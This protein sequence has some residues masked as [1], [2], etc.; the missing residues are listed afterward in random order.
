MITRLRVKNYKSLKDLDLRLR[1]LTVF[2]GPNNAG[3]SNILDSLIFLSDLVKHSDNAT[4]N[5]GGLP[6]IVWDGDLS[7]TI[8]ILLEGKIEDVQH[9]HIS[10]RYDIE[11]KAEAQHLTFS[12]EEFSVSLDGEER[13]LLDFSPSGNGANL[14]DIQR[15]QYVPHAKPPREPY[16]RDAIGSA[17]YGPLHEFAKQVSEWARY[18]FYAPEMRNSPDAR[19]ALRLDPTGGN[20]SAVLHTLQ[21]EHRERLD[22]IK[23]LLKVVV[24]DIKKLVSPLTPQGKVT[25]RAEEEGLSMPVFLRMLSNGTLHTLA[26]FAALYTPDPPPL[27]CFEEPENYVHPAVL[28]VLAAAFR[29]ASRRSQILI[30][31]H[32]PHLLNYFE[33]QD[34][35]IVEKKRG[36]TTARHVANGKV[37]KE[38]LDVMGLGEFWYSGALGGVPR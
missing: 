29:G 14:Y 27:M 34:V 28:D 10:F 11:G 23:D 17:S 13:K 20:L 33:V 4:D 15:R 2:V 8:S 35:V 12:R 16:L 36:S 22:R 31:T 30:A 37:L 9:R 18:E 3:K 21:S 25:L 26:I 32:S 1:P 38:A 24:P 19:G 6:T 5:H 7:R